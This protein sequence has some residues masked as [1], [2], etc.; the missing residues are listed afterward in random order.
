MARFASPILCRST[1]RLMP[2][3]P[4]KQ[5]AQTRLHGLQCTAQSCQ[6]RVA[7]SELPAQSCPFRVDSDR[8]LLSNRVAF[9]RFQTLLTER[10]ASG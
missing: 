1:F 9:L 8:E 10:V 4:G 5:L 7:S 3:L 2:S 6:L